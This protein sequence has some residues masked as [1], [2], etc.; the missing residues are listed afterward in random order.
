MSGVQRYFWVAMTGEE[1]SIM[2]RVL[3]TVRGRPIILVRNPIVLLAV[4]VVLAAAA[5]AAVLADNPVVLAEE[6]VAADS[7]A[8]DK[9]L[10]GICRSIFL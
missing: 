7:V 10:N 3:V 6:A 4:Q 2:D 9:K 1:T 8:E 5:A